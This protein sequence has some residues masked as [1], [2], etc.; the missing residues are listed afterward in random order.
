M[1]FDRIQR[2][3]I[4]RHSRP[5][6]TTQCTCGWR[7]SVC[8]HVWRKCSGCRSLRRD[9]VD[10][11]R[12]RAASPRSPERATVQTLRCVPISQSGSSACGC[13]KT[14][15]TYGTS[16]RSRS[17]ARSQRVPR[18]RLTLRAVAIPTRVIGDGLMSAGVTPIDDAHPRA[19]VR[20]RAI[21]SQHRSLLY[22]S[23]HGCC[24]RKV[25]P[26]AWR[27]SA[28]STAGR[29]MPA[30]D[31]ASVVRA[32]C[33]TTGAG[34][35]SCSSGLAPPARCRRD[36]WRYTVRVREIGVAEQQLDRSQVC[37]RLQQMRRVA[38]PQRVR[39]DA[40]VD[41]ALAPRAARR[42]RLTF[43]V[44]GRV[45]APAVPRSGGRDTCR[46]RI[47]RSVLAQRR[48]QRRD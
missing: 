26:C 36:R 18:L 24:S 45:G 39:R 27:I 22:H 25:S 21:A 35:C 29:L 42:P 32:A 15:C 17:R 6:G 38:V 23:G 2:W 41:A 20:Q 12:R 48:E 46:G 13:V 33:S 1:Y 16:S 9:V 40:L 10:R 47:Q 37:A 7:T 5:A 4:R 44:I 19:A 28:T 11:P 30:S 31:F 8:P 3:M 14:T 34:T 43:V